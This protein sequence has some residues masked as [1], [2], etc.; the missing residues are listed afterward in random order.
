MKTKISILFLAFFALS[1]VSCKVSEETQIKKVTK[2]YLI[3]L[4]HQDYNNA[5]KLGTEQTR[6]MLEMLQS[7]AGAGIGD[8]A[9]VEDLRIDI[10][11][12]EINNDEASCRYTINGKDEKIDLV[13]IRNKWLVDM[14]K[15][16][17]VEPNAQE[18]AYQDSV[19]AVEAA[20]ND[21]IAKAQDM[22][23]YEQ[24]TLTFFDF[25]LTDMHNV[26]TS[27]S[28]SFLLTNKSNID[29]SHLWFCLY[30]SDK[31]GNLLSK[32]EVMFNK[33]FKNAPAEGDTVPRGNTQKIDIMLDKVN[34]NNIAEIFVFP[35]RVNMQFGADDYD[36][37]DGTIDY[38][39]KDHTKLKN[40]TGKEL[41][42]TY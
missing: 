27:A 37:S 24:D 34:T 29:I 10:Y 42:I 12:C 14:K 32:K 36:Y 2:E 21:S 5:K 26:N 30:F 41:I 20:Y 6:Q 22:I 35:L 13:K 38:F 17:P 39:L 33:V 11:S 23:D 28:L 4:N 9:K 40:A 8:T 19:A 31:N 1:I 7:F 18:L 3:Y 15:E 16:T 25:C